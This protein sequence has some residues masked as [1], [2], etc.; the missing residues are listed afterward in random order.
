MA[1][2]NPEGELE[3]TV[4][5]PFCTK[6]LGNADYRATVHTNAYHELREKIH[7]KIESLQNRELVTAD[8]VQNMTDDKLLQELKSILEDD[9]P[10]M[11][12]Y[13]QLGLDKEDKN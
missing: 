2:R 5:C 7:E 1:Q 10:A 6:E 4:K 11:T 3:M 13:D 9:L 8:L 12:A